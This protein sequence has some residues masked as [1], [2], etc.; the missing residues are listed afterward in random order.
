MDNDAIEEIEDNIEI[1]MP[2][3][4][5]TDPNTRYDNT[6]DNL[7]YTISS[8]SDADKFCKMYTHNRNYTG[9]KL[10]NRIQINDGTRT[11]TWTIVGFD[12]EHNRQASDGTTYDNGYGIYM[13][14]SYDAFNSP[15][16]WHSNDTSL[17]A[18]M[19]SNIHTYTLINIVNK[20]RNVLGDHIVNRNVLLS[21]NFSNRDIFKNMCT[22]AYT[23]T[24]SYSTLLTAYNST[25]T[26]GEYGGTVYDQGEANYKLPLF[27]YN[28]QS[29][30]VHNSWIRT[31]FIYGNS[32]SDILQ[33]R[34]F[35]NDSIGVES[36]MGIHAPTGLICIR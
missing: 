29:D 1:W 8:L 16:C 12:L 23:W 28:S 26:I 5:S 32:G 17:T 34:Y 7:V 15:S 19:Y 3:I 27:N 24:T 18:Y 36:A 20:I 9:L 6:S 25:G 22:S 14:S 11:S 13:M 2:E 35:W 31:C 10:G 30:L 33:A 4:D 21:S